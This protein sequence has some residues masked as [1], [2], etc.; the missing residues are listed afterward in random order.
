MILQDA[1]VL[2]LA[3]M[4]RLML[5]TPPP[6]KISIC[7]M[8]PAPRP[9]FLLCYR[10]RHACMY[11]RIL[12]LEDDEIGL[13]RWPTAR[14]SALLLHSLGTEVLHVRFCSVQDGL[15][16]SLRLVGDL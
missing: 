4:N 15:A 1:G 11:C 12:K 3:S 6:K 9:D 2:D 14:S 7:V 16:V 8:I 5:E 10:Y 13:L